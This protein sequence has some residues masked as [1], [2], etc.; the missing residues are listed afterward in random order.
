MS[1][2]PSK[3]PPQESSQEPPQ[4]PI[5]EVLPQHPS[6][7]GL[8]QDTPREVLPPE[9]VLQATA[10]VETAQVEDAPARARAASRSRKDKDDDLRPRPPIRRKTT[11]AVPLEEEQSVEEFPQLGEDHDGIDISQDG[12]NTRAK[13][14]RKCQFLLLYPRR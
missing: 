1:S 12:L 2:T 8:P 11:L 7:E 10:A 3:D 6:R 13:V 14:S 4:D 9:L 5:T